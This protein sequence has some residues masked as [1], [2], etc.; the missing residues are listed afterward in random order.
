[1]G[2]QLLIILVTFVLVAGCRT[3]ADTET[4]A[5]DPT[6]TSLD[7][8]LTF[9][10]ADEQAIYLKIVGVEHE[11][12]V[13]VPKD[14]LHSVH[15]A[16]E[17]RKDGVLQSCNLRVRLKDVALS[18]SQ[19]LTDDLS[20]KLWNFIGNARPELGDE[21]LVLIELTCDYIGRKSPPFSVEDV[22]CRGRHVRLPSEV[23]FSD[24]VAGE[25]AMALRGEAPLGPTT[26]TLNGAVSC[27]YAPGAARTPCTLRSVASG[28]L[29]E[30]L[31]ELSPSSASPVAKR[32]MQAVIDQTGAPSDQSP[33]ELMATLT[34]F[35]DNNTFD[36]DG[37]RRH[38]CRARL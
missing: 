14:L 2:Q 37:V 18:G 28:V 5:A 29:T 16:L 25:M 32:L 15:G 8:V 4:Q 33:A 31:I 17:C 35:V 1:M 12:G 24:P 30:K 11:N 7:P 34:C 26:V 38:V 21:R 13:E 22:T 19:P 20:R 10:K 36:A 27:R 6:A 9:A 23:V 3:T